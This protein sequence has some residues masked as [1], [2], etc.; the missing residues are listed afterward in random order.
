[1]RKLLMIILLTCSAMFGQNYQAGEQGRKLTLS[2]SIQL[3]LENS[4]DLKISK[5]KL[6]G[7]EAQVTAATSQ[8]LPQLNFSASY[9]RLSNIPA[10]A[11]SL[12]QILPKPVVISP[13]ILDNYMMKLTLQQPL[14]TGLR[15]FSLRSAAKSNYEASQYDYNGSMNETALK[16]QNSFWSFYK[17]ELNNRV[18]G[19]NLV[20]LKQH[21]EDT[22]NFEKNGVATKN[23]LLKLEVQYS[24]LKLQKIEADNNLDIARAAFNQTIGLP[25]EEETAIVVDSSEIDNVQKSDY[26]L[27]ELL[28]EAKSK[29][30]ELKAMEQRLNAGDKNIAAAK[31]GWLPSIFLVGDYYYSKPN[32]RYLPAVDEFKNTWDV[33]VQLNW[34]LWNWG[35]TSSQATI[36]EQNK[37]QTETS[38]SQL[39][40][41]VQIEVYQNYLTLKRA[42]E[43][44][45]TAKLGVEQAEENYRIIQEKYNTQVAS[46]TDLIDAETS[47]LQAKT[48]YNNALVD[49]E[50]AK[51][52]LDKSVGKKI[53]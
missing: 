49:Y 12:P 42:Y 53:Y 50:L 44:I 35:Y 2:E 11:I 33:G 9:M 21:L 3:G 32:S 31:S 37:L 17:A 4:K 30:N 1:M 38:L 15:L 27:D 13:V 51:V 41:A 39:K 34:S 28:S 25:L 22:K 45:N 14:F 5:A 18:I 24:N 7:A 8:L 20:Q 26:N 23:D 19:E 48:S 6:T 43:R 46:S 36:A 52:R 40:D 16:I 29:R 47:L 10:F